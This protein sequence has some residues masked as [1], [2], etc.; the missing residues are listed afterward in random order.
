MFFLGGRGG[1][2]TVKLKVKRAYDVKE[3]SFLSPDID[4]SELLCYV[5]LLEGFETRFSTIKYTNTNSKNAHCL[6]WFFP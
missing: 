5:A 6:L 3:S 4:S 2:Y 1:S